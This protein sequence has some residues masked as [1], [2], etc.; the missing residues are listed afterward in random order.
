MYT[1]II[2][3]AALLIDTLSCCSAEN[4]YCVT[5]TAT[6]CI[7]ADRLPLWLHNPGCMA[8]SSVFAFCKDCTSGSLCSIYFLS[9]KQNSQQLKMILYEVYLSP[10]HV[11]QTNGALNNIYS[12]W[13][14]NLHLDILF[15]FTYLL[16]T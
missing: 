10:C 6:S 7:V 8:A 15:V 1:T 4:V 3:V 14:M 2:L 9:R 11:K 5:P 16:G 12:S 13:H